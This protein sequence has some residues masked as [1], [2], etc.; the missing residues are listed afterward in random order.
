VPPDLASIAPTGLAGAFQVR[1]LV[2]PDLEALASAAKSA[3]HPLGVV[4]AYRSTKQ[5]SDLLKLRTKELGAAAAAR[6]VAPPGHSEH[7]L[8]TAIDFTSQGL[9]D[10]SPAWGGTPTGR[11]MAEHSWEYGFV[12]SYPAHKLAV[13]CYRSEPWHFRYVGR[14][15]AAKV[16]ESG[17]TLREYLWSLAPQPTPAS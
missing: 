2:L 13:T 14:R 15:L 17:L 8:G 1:S 11:W 3:G 16:H 10:V 6:R 5:Q 4:A 12:L 7:Q 9:P